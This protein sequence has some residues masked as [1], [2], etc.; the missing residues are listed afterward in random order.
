MEIKYLQSRDWRAVWGFLDSLGAASISGG[1]GPAKCSRHRGSF[2]ELIENVCVYLSAL[3]D[4]S[5]ENTT[6][7]FKAI[8]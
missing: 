2:I 7:S 1:L 6:L 3:L 4:F 8:L 5:L